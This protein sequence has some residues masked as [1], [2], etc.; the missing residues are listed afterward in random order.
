MLQAGGPLLVTCQQLNIQY[1]FTH[2]S[3]HLTIYKAYLTTAAVKED[4]PA[5]A[6]FPCNTASVLRVARKGTLCTSY[7]LFYSRDLVVVREIYGR[8]EG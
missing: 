3:S 7:K 2:I 1:I 6:D 5:D 4:I 8:V